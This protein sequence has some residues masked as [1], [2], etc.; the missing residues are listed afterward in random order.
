MNKYPTAKCLISILTVSPVKVSGDNK[1]SAGSN[2]KLGEVSCDIHKLSLARH[3]RIASPGISGELRVLNDA[4][5]TFKRATESYQIGNSRKGE[6]YL[7]SP[8]ICYASLY[9]SGPP[10]GGE[11]AEKLRKIY[12]RVLN[13]SNLAQATKELKI[14]DDNIKVLGNIREGWILLKKQRRG[15]QP[16]ENKEPGKKD[17]PGG[18]ATSA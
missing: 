11:I 3:Q 10:N 13:E 8:T 17:T 16:L 9:H 7:K 15:D 6:S 1:L 4:I 2:R 5:S 14:I 18:F 12:A